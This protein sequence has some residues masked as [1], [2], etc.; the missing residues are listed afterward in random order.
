MENRESYEIAQAIAQSKIGII[1]MGNIGRATAV[2]L[3]NSNL[4]SNLVVSNRSRFET[5]NKSE[6]LIADNHISVAENNSQLV[7]SCDMIIIALKQAQMR[8]E[9]ILW[10]ESKILDNS[11]LLIS[12]AAGVRIDTIKKWVGNPNQPIIRIMPNTPVAIGKGVF[13][14]TVS[15]EVTLGQIKM[16]QYILGSL[17]TQ[18]LV[19]SDED[20]DSITAISGS[21]PAYFYLFA[22]FVIREAMN[23]GIQQKDAER[24]VQQTFIGA[25]E[26]LAHSDESLPDLRKKI[27]SKG[28]TTEKAIQSF[29]EDN[30]YLLI[31]KAMMSAKKRA[32][33]LG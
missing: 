10:K 22:E 4:L 14:W 9:L 17:G 29:N 3:L 32:G 19:K 26:L 15:N 8:E 18:Y 27:T 28:G 30:L 12:F 23:M 33:E 24:I 21:G 25:G 13:G 20:I 5:I 31:K 6:A 16:I 1:G 11:K 7:H 2:G